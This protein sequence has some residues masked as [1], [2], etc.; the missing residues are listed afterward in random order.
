MVYLLLRDL[1]KYNHTSTRTLV[2]A[3]RVLFCITHSGSRNGKS[4]RSLGRA[5]D[6]IEEVGFAFSSETNHSTLTAKN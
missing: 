6:S 3:E 1:Y 4:V 2:W 5:N